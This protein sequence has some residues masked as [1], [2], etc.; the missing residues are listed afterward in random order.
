MKT[1]L[2]IFTIVFAFIGMAC[3]PIEDTSLREEFAKTGTPITSEELTAAL[4]VTQLPNIEGEERGDQYVIIDNARKDIPGTWFVQT[5]AGMKQYHTDHDTVVY[6]ANG[7]YDIYFVGLSEKQAITSKSFRVSVTH[8]PLKEYETYL[9]GAISGA[10]NTNAKKAWRLLQTGASVYQG[11]YGNWKY[12]DMNPG[13]NSWGTVTITPDVRETTVVFE[14]DGNKIKTYSA[15]GEQIQEGTWACI[16]K[17]PVLDKNLDVWVNQERVIYDLY[18]TIPMP[19]QNLLSSYLGTSPYWILPQVG[20][21][22]EKLKEQ[23]MDKIE[24]YFPVYL[25]NTNKLIICSPSTYDKG[26]AEDWDIDAGYFFLETV[27]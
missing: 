22:D 7:K 21:T 10:D 26:A 27:E 11:M 12:Y 13:L 1:K 15:S 20:A 18:T 16:E 5:A 9:S 2:Y 24:N 23:P 14:Y 6:T 8:L 3:N 19:G 17:V 25:P 4:S